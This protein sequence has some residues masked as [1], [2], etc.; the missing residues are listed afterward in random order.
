MTVTFAA[1]Q[2]NCVRLGLRGSFSAAFA[3]VSIKNNFENFF[4]FFSSSK[5]EKDVGVL[6][7]LG[8]R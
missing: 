1:S 2:I 7:D 8:G 6:E 5:I 4:S 3:R